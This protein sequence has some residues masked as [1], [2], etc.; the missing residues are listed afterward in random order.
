MKKVRITVGKGSTGKK[1]PIFNS[2]E[3][4]Y[5]WMHDP[6]L[7]S[8]SKLDPTLGSMITLRPGETMEVE[9]LGCEFISEE[10]RHIRIDHIRLAKNVKVKTTTFN[11]VVGIHSGW[12]IEEIISFKS[13]SDETTK[14]TKLTSKSKHKFDIKNLFAVRGLLDDVDDQKLKQQDLQ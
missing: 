11:N 9:W 7:K 3:S 2:P 6:E 4:L 5:V 12:I 8:S 14:R 10:N 13:G 1:F